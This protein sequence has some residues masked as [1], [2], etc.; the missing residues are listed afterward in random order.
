M[1]FIARFFERIMIFIIGAISL[2]IIATQIFKRL[3]QIFPVFFALMFTYLV[4][5][6]IFLPRVVQIILLL[7]RKGR[8]PRFNRARDGFHVDPVNIILIGNKDQ[9]KN[10]FKQ[11]GW[12]QA[13]TLNIKSA[14][15]M[16]N[17]FIKNKPYSRAPFSSLYLFGRRQ[18]IG[19]QEPIGNSPRKRHHIRF[20][21][22]NT[23][24]IDDPLDIK[25]WTK[26]Q[27]IDFSKV[28]V[29]IGSGSE[30]LGFAFT[31]FTYQFSHKVNP[32]VDQERK[33]ILS[34]LKKNN[35]INKINYYK[36]GMF[37]VGKYTSDGR[38]A[39]AKLKNLNY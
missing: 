34:A 4:S 37:T 8:I 17:A 6:Y 14:L 35:C 10:V 13:D 30:D 25:F 12:S 16:I 21:G 36:P 39:V 29:W 23:N 15:K 1:K 38:I 32:N 19:F 22:T 5:A 27:K 3:D 11:I 26:K 2:W 28:N 7:S 9:L 18:D 20:W 31:Q 24:K 33:Y